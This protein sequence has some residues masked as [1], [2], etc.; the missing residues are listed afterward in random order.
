MSLRIRD[1]LTPGLARVA[2]R[3]GDNRPM[4]EAMGAALQGWVVASLLCL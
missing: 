3:I 1:T 4:L 2:R